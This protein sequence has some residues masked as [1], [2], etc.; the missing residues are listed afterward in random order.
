MTGWTKG[1]VS[2]IK[3]PPKALYTYL[4]SFVLQRRKSPNAPGMAD[5]PDQAND[6]VAVHFKLL[7]MQG[8]GMA[9]KGEV[10]ANKQQG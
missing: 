7:K 4:R 2:A 3:S 10:V 5:S 6:F 9:A 1:Y 8:I